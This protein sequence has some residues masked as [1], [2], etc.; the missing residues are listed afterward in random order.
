MLEWAACSG[1][2]YPL[3]LFGAVER[4]EAAWIS[5]KRFRVGKLEDGLNVNKTTRIC[6]TKE[7]T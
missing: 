2:E 3:L 6:E 4:G 7:V 5:N 1:A